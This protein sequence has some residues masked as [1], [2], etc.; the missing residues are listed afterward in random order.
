MRKI[1]ND[2]SGWICQKKTYIIKKVRFC[3]KNH[4]LNPLEKFDFLHF[5]KSYFLWSR[6]HCLICPRNTH[7]KVLF[8]DQNHGLT[9]LKDFHW[10][11]FLKTSFFWSEK[12]SFLCRIK[13]KWFFVAW[14]AQKTKMIKSSIFSQK[15]LKNSDFLD[16]S[17]TPFFWPKKPSILFRISKNDL[18]FLH[19]P[20][21][22]TW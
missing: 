19:L 10:L 21:K 12:H 18:F 14:L 8:F 17:K 9:S 11:D 2:L 7:K 15:P 13:K 1:K 6:K 3:D 20:K 5:F 16:F 22:R 4:G